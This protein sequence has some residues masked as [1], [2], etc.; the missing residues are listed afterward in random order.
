MWVFA[1][2]DPVL[3]SVGTCALR[4]GLWSV[5]MVAWCLF[6]RHFVT[7][8][9]RGLT[10]ALR[11][12]STPFPPILLVVGRTSLHPGVSFHGEVSPIQ[13]GSWPCVP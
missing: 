1:S 4:V 8:L 10:F 12:Y 3:R 11:R 5:I 7:A 2:V 6:R 9:V 13:S